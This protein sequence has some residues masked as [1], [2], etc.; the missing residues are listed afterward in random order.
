MDNLIEQYFNDTLSNTQ[1][2][3]TYSI[4][5]HHNKHNVLFLINKGMIKFTVFFNFY[6]IL[7]P[8][9]NTFYWTTQIPGVHKQF[10][11]IVNDIKKFKLKS[12]NKLYHKLLNNHKI[13]LDNISQ[14]NDIKKLLLF[15][16][17]DIDIISPISSQNKFQFIGITKIIEKY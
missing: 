4:K 12:D 10:T 9:N 6:G 2:V 8:T 1:F 7:D 11:S 13:Q 17:K 5:F 3:K 14:I 15:I 16:N